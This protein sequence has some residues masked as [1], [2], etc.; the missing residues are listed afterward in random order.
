MVH[1]PID[2][3]KAVKAVALVLRYLERRDLDVWLRLD[4]PIP[5]QKGMASSTADIVSSLAATAAA[6]DEQ[7]SVQQQAELA[8]QI[9][10]SDGVM[11][12]GVALFAHRSGRIAHS[13]GDPPAMRVLVLEF[14]HTVDTAVFNSVSRRRAL[15]A[16]SARFLEA[17]HLIV[18]GIEN[19]D[20]RLI[21]RGATLD[22]L[23]YQDVFPNPHLEA[24]LELGRAT[25]A[26]GVNVAHSGT[27]MGLLY[28]RDEP[29]ILRAVHHATRNI[30]GLTGVH[31]HR[32]IGGG[33]ASPG[34][35]R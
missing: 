35:G 7:L 4:S 3:P 1:G 22:A 8:L 11:L 28:R 16:Q 17:L 25:G 26:R 2:S 10:P 27:A 13:L 15:E 20:G 6:V 34:Q 30:P 5:R 14:S 32:L 23:A 24:V 19:G 31:H 18:A 9:E 29:Q 12:P 33:S 21:G